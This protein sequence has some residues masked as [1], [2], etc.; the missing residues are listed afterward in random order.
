MVID[1]MDGGLASST[2]D[3]SRIESSGTG[4]HSDSNLSVKKSK[5]K[6]TAWNL[7]DEISPNFN[8][9]FSIMSLYSSIIA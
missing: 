5:L 6:V 3:E 2:A 1:G 4:L 7:V 9:S 8:G